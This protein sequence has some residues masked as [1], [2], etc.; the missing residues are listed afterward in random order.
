MAPRRSDRES[1]C[2]RCRL[3][4][5]LGRVLPRALPADSPRRRDRGVRV[6]DTRRRPGRRGPPRSPCAVAVRARVH[7]GHACVPRVAHPRRVQG[8]RR[9]CTIPIVSTGAA[10][11]RIAA[12]T[13][14]GRCRAPSPSSCCSPRSPAPL[15]S[16][17]SWPLLAWTALMG[18]EFFASA[19]L[20]ARPI[21]YVASHAAVVPLIAVAVAA[22]SGHAPD[23]GAI[24]P[25]LALTYA[26]TAVF[27]F[28]RK[29]RAPPD[30]RT[31]VETY[32]ALWGRR[33]AAAAWTA[34]LCDV[35]AVGD[36]GRAGTRRPLAGRR[37]QRIGNR[38]FHGTCRPL[39]REPHDPRRQ[40]DRGALGDLAGRRLPGH[41]HRRAHRAA[42]RAP[43]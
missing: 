38:R 4:S 23:V 26:S 40:V 30:E 31:G 39:C 11:A 10:G 13:R 32:S 17:L 3:S 1:R 35:G 24:A 25:F 2:D 14:R 6:R 22:C 43:P 42:M 5:S 9:R 8:R 27:E 19:W 20:R 41:R 21:A 29:I 12:R 37:T 34:T 36:R 28:G 33:I 7:A 15:R 16:R 18:R